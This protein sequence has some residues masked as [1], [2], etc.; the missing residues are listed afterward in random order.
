MRTRHVIAAGLIGLVAGPAGFATS[1][2]AA[3]KA[4][5][6]QVRLSA[7]ASCAS[8]V[9][10]GD[11]H[12]EQVGVGPAP[13]RQPSGGP[14]AP[15][16]TSTPGPVPA[17]AQR[18]SAAADSFSTTNVQEAGV[19]EPDIVK[20]D[21]RTIFAVAGNQL[22]AVDAHTATPKLLS[23]VDLEPG[24]RHELLIR[25]GR[26]LVISNAFG[27]AAYA[28][29]QVASSPAFYGGPATS[30]V[31]EFD[32]RDPA[33]MKPVERLEIEGRYVSARQ[34]GATA[35]IV[36]ASQPHL[37][38]AAGQREKI[39]GYVPSV[40][41]VDERT[42][43]RSERLL[44]PCAQVRRAPVFAGL[45]VVSIL[46][47]NLD[48]GLPAVEADAIVTDADTVYASTD[49]L[50]VAT[51]RWYDPSRPPNDPDAFKPVTTVH[52]FAAPSRPETSYRAS[53]RVPGYLLN[54]FSLSEH[55]DVLRIASTTT[56][57]FAA[58]DDGTGGE[59][60]RQS[61]SFV[62]TLAERAGR[63]ETVGRVAG[64]GRGEQIYA[65][66]FIGDTGYVVTFRQTDPLYTIDLS[67][68]SAPRVLGELK[69]LG[70]S[71][72]LH[73]VGEDLVLGIGQD[74]TAEGRRKGAQLSLFDVSDLRRPQR[75]A[76][77]DLG[78]SSYSEVENDHRAFLYW[79]PQRL[80]V[81]PFQSYAN[82]RVAS[83]AQ[84]F[85]VSRAKGIEE[86]GAVSHG[87]DDVVRRS[88][89]LGDRLLTL[90]ER[91][92]GSSRLKDLDG[93]DLAVFP[94]PPQPEP[95]PDGGPQ[96]RPEPASSGSAQPAR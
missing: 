76:Q 2:A 42:D 32:V 89:V 78:S 29:R 40:T 39:K 77:R 62:T 37:P 95:G 82:D 41:L 50:Y 47:V 68:P 52:R 18:E 12:A 49:S 85:R 58:R 60:V 22:H 72:Y 55:K 61:E 43:Q 96:G 26:A 51:Q 7:F 86:V 33:A 30:V 23:S 64:L 24:Y 53:G 10:Y 35:R 27:A 11:L 59:E 17:E 44:V 45:D 13:R 8:L 88:L 84:G 25:N 54:Q 73:P 75:L 16:A 15:V 9:R 57:E 20:S 69:I 1:A 66:R 38:E 4:R 74:A 91:G 92:L 19:D 81:V 65:V 14:F 5:K 90:S 79:G 71:A 56:P 70:Y 36:V 34:T 83:G 87:R 67:D 94:R 63:L 28:E 6:A 80:A 93:L 3:P 48:K 21:G 46:T 31:A